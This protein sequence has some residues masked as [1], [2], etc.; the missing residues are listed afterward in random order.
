MRSG[1]S[2][3]CHRPRRIDENGAGA[4]FFHDEWWYLCGRSLS[5]PAGWLLPH[6]EHWVTLHVVAY[7]AIAELAGTSSYL[8]FR[9]ALV[10]VHIAASWGVYALARR[11]AR[12]W[13]AAAAAAI[14]LFLGSGYLNLFWGFQI[15]FVG[16][17]ALGIWALVLLPE[18][19]RAAALLLLAAV[20]TQGTGL[21]F[22]VAAGA[23]LVASGRTRSAAWLVLPA[24]AFGVWAFL[25][26]NAVD[27]RGN[28]SLEGVPGFALNGIADTLGATIG[29]GTLAAAAAVACIVIARP[30]RWRTPVTISC[31]A[32]LLAE[33][34]AIGLVREGFSD[35]GTSHY[36]YVGAMLVL[37]AAA[38]IVPSVRVKA[39]A[40][41]LFAVAL[42]VNTL[43]LVVHGLGWVAET[44]A[45]RAAGSDVPP[46]GVCTTSDAGAHGPEAV[47]GVVR[48]GALEPD[49]LK[50]GVVALDAHGADVLPR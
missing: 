41:A 31:A 29:L 21:F 30:T 34:V 38:V 12:P 47:V 37:P 10:A 22:V 43:L 39:L 8:P 28:M 49:D 7:R 44:N 6:N 36:L 19:P 11:E 27:V 2:R 14:M 33:F 40:P 5:D 46:A 24:G 48:V 23:R 26:R 18:R 9:V 4:S 1:W 13:A 42:G 3:S 20:A 35:P 15:G 50:A 17:A 16:G 25:F 45:Q 32:G